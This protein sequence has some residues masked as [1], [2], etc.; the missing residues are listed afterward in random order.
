MS[1]SS[2]AL[3]E[4]PHEGPHG[5]RRVEERKPHRRRD[6]NHGHWEEE[7]RLGW[8]MALG[9]GGGGR[10]LVGSPSQK[11]FDVDNLTMRINI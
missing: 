7:G 5:G 8:G 11:V 2:K 1:A 6:S 10:D 9:P 3:A 4:G